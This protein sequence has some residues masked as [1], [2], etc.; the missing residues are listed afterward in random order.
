M[1]IR[2][3]KSSFAVQYAVI[4]LI[5]LGFFI[6]SFIY[7]TALDPT[8][9]ING[10]LYEPLS[11][12]FQQYPLVASLVAFVLLLFQAY[13]FNEILAYNG[14]IGRQSTIGAFL[15]ILLFAQIPEQQTMY[16]FLLAG[17]F[18]LF[19]LNFVFG[20]DEK[21][22]NEMDI[23]KV[24][25]FISIASLFYFPAV[26]LVFWIWIALLMSR[27]GSLRELLIPF[28]GMVS[29]YFFLASWYYLTNS[30]ISHSLAYQQVIFQF[31]IPELRFTLP[32][33]VI[34]TILLFMIVWFSSMIVGVSSEKNALLRKKRAITNALLFFSLPTLFYTED[35]LIHN[36]LIVIPIAL[37][38]S[39]AYSNVKGKM[40]PEILLWLLFLA[41]GAGHF[42]PY[43]T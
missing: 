32:Q 28:V 34:W 33:L 3:F 18:I 37:L 23:F 22:D 2:F 35:I 1:L 12:F 4:F 25:I 31:S 15:F 17:I 9:T 19:A 24:S 27:S 43:F 14:F 13:Y 29:P 11:V 6:P 41:I 16:P 26:L 7:P 40:V 5:T 38:L 30:L 36:G 8:T 42:L 20:L 10:P 39:Y 21:T